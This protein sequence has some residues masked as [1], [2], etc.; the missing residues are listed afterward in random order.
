MC[1]QKNKSG[2]RLKRAILIGNIWV[3]MEGDNNQL[4]PIIKNPIYAQKA[5]ME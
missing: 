4:P 2:N 3:I 5:N 1:M